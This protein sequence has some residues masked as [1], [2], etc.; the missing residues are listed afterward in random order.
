MSSWSEGGIQ[1]AGALRTK[2]GKGDPTLSMSCSDKM[3][4]WNVT[5]CQGALA[6]HFLW[7]PVYLESITIGGKLFSAVACHRAFF[8][9]LSG[10]ALSND[11]MRRGYQV[12]CPEIRH[13]PLVREAHW[14]GS[15]NGKERKLAP[16]GEVVC[17]LTDQCST[18]KICP[19]MYT[20]NS[21][22]T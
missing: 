8:G 21:F 19:Y 12:H 10:C 1:M 18:M 20:Q 11:V 13:I 2:P 4:R 7:H 3:M 16:G 14:P 17:T 9:R 22:L 15:S 5:G 6:S